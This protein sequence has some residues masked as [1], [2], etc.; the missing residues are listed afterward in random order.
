MEGHT[1][2]KDVTIFSAKYQ[3]LYYQVCQ[4][5]VEEMSSY[6]RNCNS[7]IDRKCMS[8]L[9]YSAHSVNTDEVRS[10]I[11]KLNRRKQDGDC[12]ISTDYL[13]HGTHKLNAHI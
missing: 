5:D 13:I 11:S 1:G 9:C 4:Y 12:K 2:S 10:A 6:I 3:H 7:E 8:G